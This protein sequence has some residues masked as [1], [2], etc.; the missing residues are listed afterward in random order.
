VLAVGDRPMAM[1]NRT[2]MLDRIL[3]ALGRPGVDGILGSADIIDDLL[4]L[5]GAL[6][7]KVV[8]GS[9]NR[10]GLPGH[11]LR[12]RRPVHWIQRHR[13]RGRRP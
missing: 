2:D 10:G 1:A 8:L 6:D 7:H 12:N 4:L 9:M 13:D 5:L 3:V 11:G